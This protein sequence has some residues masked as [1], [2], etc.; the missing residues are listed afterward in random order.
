MLKIP[1]GGFELDESSF[2]LENK[3]LS[4]QPVGW[5]DLT[6]KPFYE[7]TV[8]K[9]F[10]LTMDGV[11]ITGFTMPAVGET[12]TVK[13]NGV[14]SVETVKEA[15]IEGIA[16]S[17]IGSA[18]FATI[19]SGG[20]GW[21]IGYLGSAA[22]LASPE[23]VVSLPIDVV[24]QI[25]EKFVPI[26]DVIWNTSHYTGGYGDLTILGMRYNDSGEFVTLTYA[27]NLVVPHN[28]V[29]SIGNDG[30]P[31]IDKVDSTLRASD[32]GAFWLTSYIFNGNTSNRIYTTSEIYVDMIA[33]SYGYTLT[34]APSETQ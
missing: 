32:G 22:A 24:H 16:Y 1:C 26:N 31:S 28:H 9:D 15:E 3:K 30:Y 25:E 19:D 6:D 10:T 27:P 33:A 20:N 29:L 18:D 8:W 21:C 13:V 23:T 12:V 7:E 5:N 4:T 17:Y 2:S 14:E 34:S 11:E